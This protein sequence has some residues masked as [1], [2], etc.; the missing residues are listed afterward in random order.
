[1]GVGARKWLSIT[2]D[3]VAFELDN[4]ETGELLSDVTHRWVRRNPIAARVTIISA[5]ALIIAHLAALLDPEFDV[6]S[7]DFRYRKRRPRSR[8]R[9]WTLTSVAPY[10]PQGAD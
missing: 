6:L 8:D 5:G 9:V 1:M 4:W 10:A 2:A 3:I 7:K